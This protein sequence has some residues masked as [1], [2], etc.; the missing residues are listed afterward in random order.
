MDL[1]GIKPEHVMITM[2]EYRR[3]GRRSFPKKYEFGEPR[4][5]WLVLEGR[6]YPAKAIVGAAHDYA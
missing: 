4:S 5:Q 1:A 2:A 6:S 3:I